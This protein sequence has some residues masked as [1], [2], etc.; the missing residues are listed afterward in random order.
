MD[1]YIDYQKRDSYL[2]NNWE[3]PKNLGRREFFFFVLS[4]FIS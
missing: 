2:G 3:C 4:L 1:W